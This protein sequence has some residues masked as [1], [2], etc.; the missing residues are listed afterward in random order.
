MQFFQA[1]ENVKNSCNPPRF[2]ANRRISIVYIDPMNVVARNAQKTISLRRSLLVRVGTLVAGA[3]LLFALL[4]FQFGM[5]PLV[6]RIAESQF[7]V[8]AEHVEASLDSLFRPAEQLLKMGR[9]W[10]A[11]APPALDPPSAFNRLFMPVLEELPQATSMVAGT[12]AG[13]GWMLLQRPEG[14]WRNRLTDLQRWGN[15]HLFIEHEPDGSVSRSWKTVDYDPRQRS[16]YVTAATAQDRTHWTKP[17]SFFTTGDPGV[18]ASISFNLPDGRHFVLGIDLMLRDLSRA[19]IEARLGQH[20]MALVLTEDLRVLALPSP[21]REIALEKWLDKI[22]RPFGE[23]G[24]PAVTTAMKQAPE[25][26]EEISTFTSNGEKWLSRL[27]P[28]ALGEQKLWVLTLAPE[29]DFAPGWQP[30]LL[31]IAAALGM[32]LLL[33]ALFA[34]YQARRIAQPVEALATLNEKIG[35]LDFTPTTMPGTDIEEIRKLAV[36]QDEMRALLL[37]HQQQIATQEAR[38]HNQIAA[39]SAA[40]ERIRESEAYNRVLYADSRLALLVLD[41]ETGRFID[42]NPA[43][44]RIYGLPGTASVI[45]K[46]P[47]QLSTSSQYDGTPSHVAASEAI[48]SVLERGATIRE[49]HH[50]RPDGSEWDG[51]VHL[52]PFHS[53]G[54]LLIQC[55]IQ[56]VTHRKQSMLA[57]E[58]L[59]LHDTLTGLFNRSLF[60]DRLQQA[61]ETG[62]RQGQGVAVLYLDLDRFKEI[63]DTHGHTVGDDVLREAGRRFAA[64]LH[65]GEVLA[66][67]G[68]DEFAILASGGDQAAAGFI[69]E[70]LI[71]S[72]GA[73]IE[74]GNNAFSLG[75]SIGISRFPH[76]GDTPDVLLRHADTAMYRAK[77]G[78]RGYMHYTAQMS[79]GIAENILLARDLKEAL[80]HRNEELSLFYQPQFELRSRRLLGAEALL[81]WSHPTLGPISPEVFIPIAESRG[82]MTLL[83]DWVLKEAC[84]QIQAW[85]H[86]GLGFSG[87]MG[88]N[89][90]AQQIEDACF[91]EQIG[92]IVRAGGLEPRLFELELTESGMMR[93]I[94]QSIELFTQLN[95]T[96]FSLAID[97]FGTGYSSLSYLKRLPARKMKI[98][99]SFVRDMVDDANDHTIVATI[100]AM[101]RTLG[102]RTIAE[103]VAT[104]AQAD[105]L[106]ALGCDEAQGHFF[107]MPE[108]GDVFA[109]K[110]L[111]SAQTETRR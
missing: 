5:D 25:R 86:E 37:R 38:L 56:D 91:P 28:Y 12:S 93:N 7:S 16:W 70:R 78:G 102:M 74:V 11:D 76:D 41:P 82:M 69:A 99:K 60:L 2:G 110:W 75:V 101:G 3:V 104:A 54:R 80:R 85:R 66:R 17:Y 42:C 46:S 84:R 24:L 29:A 35:R 65:D 58:K 72:L 95:A 47:A 100:I 19:T 62:R 20:G 107:G 10:I 1:P 94:E 36:A 8:A 32:L 6:R 48:R 68:G 50:R 105:A 89:I 97:D 59:A 14:G 111:R 30:I 64:A 73:R 33:V 63:N 106:L 40:E 34:S 109:E 52:L 96:G 67:L 88:I 90:A 23:L 51:E 22:L 103:G 45:G 61:L 71:A 98:D 31:P 87:R 26:R 9:T 79:S 39:L 18:T 27:H 108:P 13:E 92:E 57:L 53:A 81:H 55:S 77:S 21:P 4:F 43:A 44:A 49:W 83:G 15:K